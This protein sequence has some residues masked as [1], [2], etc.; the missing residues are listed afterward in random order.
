MIYC[1][2]NRLLQISFDIQAVS[3][4][5]SNGQ[6]AFYKLGDGSR[7]LVPEVKMHTLLTLV[8]SAVTWEFIL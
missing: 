4:V 6:A 2:G 8:S 5:W 1:G 3:Y 7:I